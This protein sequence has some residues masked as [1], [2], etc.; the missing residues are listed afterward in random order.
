MGGYSIKGYINNNKKLDFIA[1][2]NE[3]KGFQFDDEINYSK[4]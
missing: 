4:N 3:D 1:I 2:M